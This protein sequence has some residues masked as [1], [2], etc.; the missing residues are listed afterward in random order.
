MRRRDKSNK[1]RIARRHRVLAV[2]AMERRE[3]LATLL[4]NGVDDT[5]AR[6]PELT[7]R[8]AIEVVD[9]TL[10]VSSLSAGEQAQISGS[11]GGPPDQIDFAIPGAGVHTIAVTYPLPA[12]TVPVS[13]DGTSQAGWKAN[14]LATGDNAVMP[15]VLDG[16]G[17]GAL[18]DGLTISGGRSTVRGLV[19]SNFS[20]NG[21]SLTSPASQLT[22]AGGN[23]IA[24]NFIGTDAGGESAEGNKQGIYLDEGSND[25][26]GGTAPADR[27]LISGS[28]GA[29]LSFMSASITG[30]VVEG[31]L[32]GTDAKAASALQN[33]GGIEIADGVSATTI[34]GTVAGAGNVIA[35]NGGF[36]V[37]ISHDA[38]SANLV[39]ENLIYANS[40]VPK[41]AFGAQIEDDAL[42]TPTPTITAANIYPSS[43]QIQGNLPYPSEI[44]TDR[45]EVYTLSTAVGQPPQF[46]GEADSVTNYSNEIIGAEETFVNGGETFAFSPTVPIAPGQMLVATASSLVA[47]RDFEDGESAAHR[48][49]HVKLLGPIHGGRAP[50]GRPGDLGDYHRRGGPPRRAVH[51]DVHGQEQRPRRRERRGAHDQPSGGCPDGAPVGRHLAAKQRF[52][53]VPQGRLVHSLGGR[54]AN[55]RELYRFSIHAIRGRQPIRAHASANDG[56]AGNDR[57]RLPGGLH[58]GLAGTDTPPTTPS[59]PAAVVRSDTYDTNTDDKQFGTP[60]TYTDD[61]D[62]VL[63]SVTPSTN[64]PVVGQPLTYTFVV[65]NNGPDIA[66]G[67]VVAVALPSTISDSGLQTLIPVGTIAPGSSQTATITVHPTALGGFAATFDATASYSAG[68]SNASNNDASLTSSIQ[69]LTGPKVVGIGPSS[70]KA[71]GSAICV[72][73]NESIDPATA[74]YLKNYAI[75]TAGR[76]RK[77]GTKDDV[78]YAIASAQ[79]L[80]AADSVV[81]ITKRK[82]SKAQE[83]QLIVAGLTDAAG[84]PL[85]GGTV[86]VPFGRSAL[87][88]PRPPKP[89]KP[90]R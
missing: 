23:L 14:D 29:G 65:T 66:A 22:D 84:T 73:F 34:G 58:A 67:V 62:L 36:G 57:V 2:E 6:D 37:L 46:V 71:R 21:I 30:T 50:A 61:Y 9:G 70:V 4:V 81:L 7:L 31:N 72:S 75:V 11:L 53:F 12:I 89:T 28:F 10:A 51:G 38:G 63:S 83:Y 60:L 32:I 85:D 39:L 68:E 48:R 3:L 41:P 13:I 74:I 49:E 8:E 35:G 19:I 45:I 88:V 87:V 27:N 26:I 33:A 52:P 78:S 25:T 44:R 80:P 42:A 55:R 90:R 15:I 47:A 43:T 56:R 5:N 40:S 79:Y 59:Q 54:H 17:A 77:F 20:G 16:S 18:A 1:F 64:A 76:D 86:K 24:G 69:P 82:L